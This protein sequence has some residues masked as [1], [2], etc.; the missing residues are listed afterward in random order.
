M[1]EIYYVFDVIIFTVS[2]YYIFMNKSVVLS[3]FYESLKLYKRHKL[4]FSILTS[5]FIYLFLQAL[6]LPPSNFDS[7]V[8]NH[9][10]VLLFKIEGDL[11]LD[12]Y[13][14]FTQVAFPIGYDILSFLFLRYHTDYGLAV[15]SFLS[16]TVIV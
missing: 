8:Y 4:I 15:F 10:G 14:N 16:Y 5:V 11:F 7:M 12:N 13:M 6:L 1:H 9:A 2:F 3:T